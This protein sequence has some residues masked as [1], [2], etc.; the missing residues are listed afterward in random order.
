M[1]RSW[2]R[3]PPWAPR[4]SVSR[5]F[6]ND[7]DT[8]MSTS[9]MPASRR[10]IDRLPYLPGLD[11]LRAVAVVAVMIYHANHRWLSGGF[12]GVEVFFVISGY[13]ITLLLIGEFERDGRIKL[14]QFWR[15]RFRRLLPPLFVMLAGLAIFMTIFRRTPMGRT[16]GDFAGGILYSSNWY[17]IVVGQGYTANEAFVP[18]R[19]LWSL[20]VEEQFYLIWPLIMTVLLA[21]RG[22]RDL[23]RLA[24]WFAGIAVAISVGMALLFH[25]GDVAATCTIDQRQGFFTLFDRCIST[26]EAL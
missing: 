22:G 2:V 4:R 11:G 8:S 9:V 21:R 26:N 6:M 7:T 13:L 14:G 15:R 18:L 5:Q 19:H 12:L 10:Q 16:S 1:R 17:Q 3:F 24:F 25:A 23:T 20:A